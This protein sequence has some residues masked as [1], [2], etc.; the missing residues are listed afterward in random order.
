MLRIHCP[1]NL[2]TF[3]TH[4]N[5]HRWIC[6]RNLQ[7]IFPHREFNAFQ[8]RAIVTGLTLRPAILRCPAL[9]GKTTL[10]RILLSL[11]VNPTI[12]DCQAIVWTRDERTTREM[13]ATLEIMKSTINI[14]SGIMVAFDDK[15]KAGTHIIVGTPVSIN[16]AWREKRLP[17]SGITMAFLDDCLEDGELGDHA[18]AM[19]ID[20]NFNFAISY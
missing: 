2:R 11:L 10:I 3:S 19:V 18:E 17:I 12:P 20:V 13:L 15:V 16:K 6:P 9:G 14:S 7:N 1:K 8:S 4:G 5:A